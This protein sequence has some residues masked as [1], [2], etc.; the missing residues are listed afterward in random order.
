VN[1]AEPRRRDRTAG[2][3]AFGGGRERAGRRSR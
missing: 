1:R 2:W 3:G